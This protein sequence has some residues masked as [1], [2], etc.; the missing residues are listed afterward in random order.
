M[1][2]AVRLQ[3]WLMAVPVESPCATVTLPETIFLS[4]YKTS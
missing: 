1:E 3:A 2:T 4:I